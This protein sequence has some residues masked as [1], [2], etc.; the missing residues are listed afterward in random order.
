MQIP[1][2]LPYLAEAVP[3]MPLILLQ[4][5][6]VLRLVGRLWGRLWG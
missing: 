3:N 1:A 6:V 2:V 4:M 5:T